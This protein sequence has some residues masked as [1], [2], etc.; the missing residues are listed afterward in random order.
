MEATAAK[1]YTPEFKALSLADRVNEYIKKTEITIT[2]IATAIHYS[3]TT[4][5]R[6]LSGRYDSDASELESKLEAYLAENAGMVPGEAPRMANPVP[7][8]QKAFFE[9]ADAQGILGVCSACQEYIGLGI[10]VG[11]TGYG[12]TYTL[13]HYAKMQRVAYLEC[14]DTMSS[15]D[16]VEAIEKSLGIPPTYGTIWK[17]VNGIREF[18]RVN[19]GYLLIID[20]ADKL[21]NKY[22]QKKMEILRA[23]FDQCDVGLVIAGEPRL[24]ASIKSYLPRFAN[25]VDFY[26]SLKGL[27]SKEVDR[28]LNR[29][30]ADEAALAELKTRACNHQTGCFRL[31][32]RTLNNIMRILPPDGVITPEIISRA[33]N[34]MML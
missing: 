18:F 3:R 27:S 14:D 28:Y 33:S 5:S 4:V 22:T 34:M 11:K 21:M 30:E 25:R 15:R 8:K 9:S 23:I 31:L 32:D 7:E 16:L 6:Y 19:R 13:K 10:V 20:E 24:E 26:A 2:E 29:Y 1:L 17:R 12:K